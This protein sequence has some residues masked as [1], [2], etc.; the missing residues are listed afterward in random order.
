MGT[1]ELPDV[2]F[3][4]FTLVIG[5]TW[6]NDGSYGLS[7]V[8]LRDMGLTYELETQLIHLSS[9]SSIGVYIRNCRKKR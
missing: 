9:Q 7:N 1:K 4:Q 3:N 2:D 8:V 6:G 5:K